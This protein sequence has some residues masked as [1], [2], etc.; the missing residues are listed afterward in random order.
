[1]LAELARI[2]ANTFAA[3]SNEQKEESGSFLSEL[4]KDIPIIGPYASAAVEY[5]QE[6]VQKGINS[7]TSGIKKAGNAVK[8]FFGFDI[9][10]PYV[11]YDMAAIVHEGE[12]IIPRTFNDAIKSGEYSLVGRKDRSGGFSGTSIYVTVNVEG[13]VIKKDD[14]I[15]EIHDGLS[16]SIIGGKLTPLPA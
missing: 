6:V 3:L 7:I 9:G 5:I 14:L 15:E 10:T 8:K 4:V 12:G 11:P 16:A 13:S 1:M 2:D